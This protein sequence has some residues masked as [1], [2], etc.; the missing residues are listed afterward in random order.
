MD[1]N[2]YVTRLKNKLFHNPKEISK[3]KFFHIKQAILAELHTK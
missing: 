3:P 2:K 1:M